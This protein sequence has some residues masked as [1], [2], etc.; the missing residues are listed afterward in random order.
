MKNSSTLSL[1][2]W[3]GY[4][5]TQQTVHDLHWTSDPLP[6]PQDSTLLPYGCGRS[7]G[8]SCLND[9]GHVVRTRALNRF[10][11][12]HPPSG[13]LEC[14]SG[15]T[16]AEVIDFALPRGYFP[17]VTP[18]TKFVTIGG[19][20]ANDVHGKNHHV[21]GTFGR[22]VDSFQLVRSSGERL[23]C[24]LEQ[25]PAL[26]QA[27]IG[28]L[29]LTGLITSA[30]FRLRPVAGPWMDVRVAEMPNLNS[31]FTHSRL[32]GEEYPYVVSW[33]DCLAT[34]KDLGRGIFLCGRHSA[35]PGPA[36]KPG[37]LPLF[38]PVEIPFSLINYPFLKAFNA[39]YR[40][41]QK[42]KAGEGRQHFEPFFYPLD[43]VGHWNRIY[44]KAGF[45]QWQCLVPTADAPAA[46]REILE[47]IAR[48]GTG[49]FLAV[50]KIMGDQPS[51]GMM[52]FNAP[53]VTL[54]LDFP[55]NPQ[56]FPLL[57]RLDE[58][59]RQAGGML[60]P[61]K[62][63]RMSGEDFRAAYP[64]WEEFSQYLDPKFSSSFWRRVTAGAH[65]H[66]PQPTFSEAI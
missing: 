58:V 31:F 25:N 5:R 66:A 51:A 14:E 12:F 8:D 50:M 29:G 28:G 24:S 55:V 2:S 18:G 40:T 48:A 3:G 54:A 34:G 30:R 10:L 44:G 64:R 61:A 15:V 52:S 11:D 46:M 38:V 21:D 47:R 32:Y 45:L 35:E 16:I 37:K 53:G 60:Y 4:P 57:N 56:V 39:L 42:S 49:S 20:I 1:R 13:E 36:V 27:T 65:R 43:A 59:V 26:F 17:P 6:D 19:A 22:F 9:G 23:T 33:V 41:A 62:D 7:Y 63:A